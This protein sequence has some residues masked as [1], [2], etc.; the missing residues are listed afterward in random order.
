MPPPDPVGGGI[1]LL[2]GQEDGEKEAL[3]GAENEQRVDQ[4]GSHTAPG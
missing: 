3:R 4:F 1:R 2:G